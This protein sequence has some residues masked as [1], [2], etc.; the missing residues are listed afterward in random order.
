MRKAILAAILAAAPTISWAQAGAQERTQTAPATEAPPKPVDGDAKA[1]PPPPAAVDEK[2]FVI[3]PEDQIGV[4]VWGDPRIG[5]NV[6]VR[7]DGRISLTLLGDVQAAGRTPAELGNDIGELLKQK[8]VLRRPQVT[9][10]VLQVNSKKYRING[11]VMKTGAFPLV[12]PTKVMDA[13]VEAGG[14]RDFANKKD[15]V[16]IR[17]EQ[18]FKF[19]WNDVVRGK[20]PEQNIYL[21]HGDIIIVK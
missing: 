9:V 10:K 17:G 18:R 20:K 8:E 16:I 19:N 21:Q 13:L 14:F 12:V 5:G 7:P 4:E 11:E 15:I 6:L 2:T 1:V 3:G